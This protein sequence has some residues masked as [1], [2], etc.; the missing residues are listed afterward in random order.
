MCEIQL[1]RRGLNKTVIF[2]DLNSQYINER[3][4][5]CNWYGDSGFLNEQLKTKTW[6][7]YLWKRPIVN[8]VPLIRIP[9]QNKV[10]TRWEGPQS[11]DPLIP[12]NGLSRSFQLCKKNENFWLNLPFLKLWIFDCQR[13]YFCL[14]DARF[15]YAKIALVPRLYFC[16]FALL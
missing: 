15:F 11:L 1:V 4:H 2:L 9:L 14:Y 5:F 3:K 13:S 10:T 16:K 12:L 7:R 8:Y 6:Q